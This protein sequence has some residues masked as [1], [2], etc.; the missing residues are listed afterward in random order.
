MVKGEKEQSVGV[1][2]AGQRRGGELFFLFGICLISPQ[3]LV[4]SAPFLC[5]GDE[6]GEMRGKADRTTSSG[7]WRS[8]LRGIG[9]TL[10]MVRLW[11]VVAFSFCEKVVWCSVWDVAGLGW[12]AIPWAEMR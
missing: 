9:V 5:V 1:I 10:C 6:S 3:S 7:F 2:D 8:E 12:Q 4:G 11:D